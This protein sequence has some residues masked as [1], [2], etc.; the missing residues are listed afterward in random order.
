MAS[1]DEDE[2]DGLANQRAL[3]E[4]DQR[5]LAQLE[6]MGEDVAKY[7]DPVVACGMRGSELKPVTLSSDRGV[8]A[9]RV[10]ALA[11][12]LGLPEGD[13]N[14]NE[15]ARLREALATVRGI[16]PKDEQERIVAYNI[17]AFSA[18]MGSLMNEATTAFGPYRERSMAGALKVNAAILKGIEAIDR[19]RNKGK[20]EIK[21]QYVNVNDGGQAVVGDIDARRID[22][23]T[24]TV[25]STATDNDAYG[26]LRSR[27]RPTDRDL[28]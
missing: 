22:R 6:S 21:V 24:T 16:G 1:K 11:S 12:M 17:V 18:S 25:A 10:R 27:R 2:D 19:H 15:R 28:E 7:R 20:K 9:Q 8:Q 23:N 13:L 26:G 14:I 4:E 3:D 5:A